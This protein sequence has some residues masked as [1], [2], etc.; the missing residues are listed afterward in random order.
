MNQSYVRVNAPYAY[1]HARVMCSEC[2]CT[3]IMH[4]R[5]F[6]RIL[7]IVNSDWL[8]HGRSVRGV[9]EFYLWDILKNKNNTKHMVLENKLP[10]YDHYYLK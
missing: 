9:Y 2:N 10:N 7:S 5:Y 6:S 4:A 1:A 8:Q 3:K